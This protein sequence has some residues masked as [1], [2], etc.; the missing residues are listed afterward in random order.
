MVI[1]IN[2]ETSLGLECFKEYENEYIFITKTH[3]N[4]HETLYRNTPGSCFQNIIFMISWG[5]PD[6]GR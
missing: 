3:Y 4:G 5:G 6:F 2:K 1:N